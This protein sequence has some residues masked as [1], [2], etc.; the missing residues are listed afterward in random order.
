MEV[1]LN[2]SATNVKY[3]DGWI[4]NLE[5]EGLL[6][7]E[8]VLPKGSLFNL[9]EGP[10]TNEQF[11][12]IVSKM[13]SLVS[14]V[15][16][17]KRIHCLNN[18]VVLSGNPNG[19][20]LAFSPF[21]TYCDGIA[22]SESEGLLD[23]SNQPLKAFWVDFLVDLDSIGSES[24]WNLKDLNSV[25]LVSWIPERYIEAI[26]HAISENGDESLYWLSQ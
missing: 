21:F 5:A 1:T 14:S 13:K 8:Q 26:D 6:F 23:E 7:K 19:Q 25:I 2:F 24:L 3:A 15:I 9:I 17:A 11:Q 4:Q 20:L 12:N 22:A 18:D 10:S 16:E